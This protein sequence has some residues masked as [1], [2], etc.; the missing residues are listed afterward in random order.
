MRIRNV[1]AADAG[2]GG[3][4]VFTAAHDHFRLIDEFIAEDVG[5]V[6]DEIPKGHEHV[7]DKGFKQ[8]GMA[9]SMAVALLDHAGAWDGDGVEGEGVIEEDKENGDAM[10][11]SGG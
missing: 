8:V 1:A 5:M 4:P 6:G 3:K 10:A 2:G 7:A 11:G 9:E